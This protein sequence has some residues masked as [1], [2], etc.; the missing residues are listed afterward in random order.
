MNLAAEA[1]VIAFERDR[2]LDGVSLA[3]SAGSRVLVLGNSGAGKTSLLKALTGLLEVTSG[4]IFWGDVPLSDLDRDQRRL[5]QARFGMVFQTDAL[6]DSLTVLDNVTLP[7]LRRKVPARE[8]QERARSALASVGLAEFAASFPERLSGGMRKRAGI[9][10]AIVAQPEVLLADDPLAGLDP[11]TG[12]T[13]CE[14]LIQA[15]AGRTLIIGATEP[16]SGLSLPRWIWLSAGKV[17]YDGPADPA[18]LDRATRETE[19]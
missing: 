2:A 7:L 16:P 19:A 5:Q 1:V 12:A 10:R 17:A 13:V 6:F 9:A 8:A 4:Q 18:V 14:V 3:L 11:H 15:S